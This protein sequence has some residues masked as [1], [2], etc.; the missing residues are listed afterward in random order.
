VD[1][2]DQHQAGCQ[3]VTILGTAGR[4]RIYLAL[5]AEKSQITAGHPFW[6]GPRNETEEPSGIDHDFSDRK[7][8]RPSAFLKWR[9]E[10][11]IPRQHGVALSKPEGMQICP[12]PIEVNPI[13]V[14]LLPMRV[15]DGAR[16]RVNKTVPDLEELFPPLAWVLKAFT[17]EALKIEIQGRVSKVLRGSFLPGWSF[18]PRSPRGERR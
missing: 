9:F 18:N 11:E 2:L 13:F 16:K 8:P 6:A 15:L 14:L 1:A 4:G 7:Q 3:Q 17:C 5:I 12:A 10:D